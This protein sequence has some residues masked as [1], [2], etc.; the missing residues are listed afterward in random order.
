ME[1]PCLSSCSYLY[2]KVVSYI[3]TLT[4]NDC[5]RKQS[6]SISKKRGQEVWEIDKLERPHGKMSL[7]V[8]VT[9]KP[10]AAT[11]FKTPNKR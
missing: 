5:L 8:F 1:Y 4:K 2:S 11:L 10:L 6:R 7:L 9:R 3:K